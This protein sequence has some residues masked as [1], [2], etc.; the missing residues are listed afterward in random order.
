MYLFIKTIVERILSENN[1][2]VKEEEGSEWPPFVEMRLME[3]VYPLFFIVDVTVLTLLFWHATVSLTGSFI[4]WSH[5]EICWRNVH[6]A[7]CQNCTTFIRD[8][9]ETGTPDVE[10]LNRV[11][12]HCH[13]KESYHFW[14]YQVGCGIRVKRLEQGHLSWLLAHFS[15]NG[16]KRLLCS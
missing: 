3:H 15:V 12:S 5:P 9:K 6:I 4:V 1:G 10:Q 14:V 7:I 8:G 11:T 16:R 2:G 13:Y